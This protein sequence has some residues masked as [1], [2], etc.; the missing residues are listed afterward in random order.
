[1]LGHVFLLGGSSFTKFSVKL[2][3]ISNWLAEVGDELPTQAMNISS[4]FQK[5]DINLMFGFINLP[6]VQKADKSTKP[7]GR[8]GLLEVSPLV[9]L[10]LKVW[11]LPLLA[12]PLEL[13]FSNYR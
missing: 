8:P 3:W 9:A 4:I 1:V 10:G 7:W 11:L 5:T 12:L 13:G 6:L 2:L